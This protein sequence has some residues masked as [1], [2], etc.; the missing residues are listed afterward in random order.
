MR[1]RSF[2]RPRCFKFLGV[3]LPRCLCED[4]HHE[5]HAPTLATLQPTLGDPVFFFSQY[6][7]NVW[8]HLIVDQLAVV[9]MKAINILNISKYYIN[10]IKSFACRMFVSRS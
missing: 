5:N 8:Q 7:K 4:L 6:F 9:R 10:D 3:C 2:T 1:C